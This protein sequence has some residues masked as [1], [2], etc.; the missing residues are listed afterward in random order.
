MSALQR[1]RRRLS[2]GGRRVCGRRWYCLRRVCRLLLLLHLLLL[3]LLPQLMLLLQLLLLRRIRVAAPILL[4]R[5]HFERTELEKGLLVFAP[6]R[7]KH[8]GGLVA[9][10]RLGF[11]MRRAPEERNGEGV[12]RG[13]GHWIVKNGCIA[14]NG[15]MPTRRLPSSESR[16][17][18]IHI[19][20]AKNEQYSF[21]TRALHLLLR[22][23]QTLLR[24]QVVVGEDASAARK[25]Q[26]VHALVAHQRVL[27]EG[28]VDGD[29][30]HAC[31]RARDGATRGI[32][33]S[34][35]RGIRNQESGEGTETRG[36]RWLHA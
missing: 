26:R 1:R 2:G 4:G 16:Y 24:E 8:V 7:P 15:N 35:N 32:E 23:L 30:D 31:V 3:L 19:T 34:E 17:E 5:Y 6:G 12:S 33:G 18:L 21:P 28:Q 29:R 13:R 36:A 22:E 25:Q 20:P 27:R 10:R 9:E 14:R 11:L